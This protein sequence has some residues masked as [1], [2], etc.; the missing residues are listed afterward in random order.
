MYLKT[1][2]NVQNIKT[3]LLN[4]FVKDKDLN[5]SLV[6]LVDAEAHFGKSLFKAF[7]EL[8]LS[9]NDSFYRPSPWLKS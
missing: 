9:L 1:I 4:S 6:D 3:N 7:A 2:E 5:K 8:Q